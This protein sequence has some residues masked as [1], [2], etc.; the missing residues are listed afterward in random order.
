MEKLND[1]IMTEK[2]Q[3]SNFIR[4]IINSDLES[5][6][7]ERRIP[8]DKIKKFLDQRTIVSMDS[9]MYLSGIGRK[10]GMCRP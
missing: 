6:K 10:N 1:R 2:E 9:S 5:G 7:N 8:R 4:V 3:P